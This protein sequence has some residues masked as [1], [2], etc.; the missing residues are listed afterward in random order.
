MQ[1]ISESKSKDKPVLTKVRLDSL[2]SFKQALYRFRG[3]Y[4]QFQRAAGAKL[5]IT[6][7]SIEHVRA[8]I[9]RSEP[10]KAQPLIDEL[11]KLAVELNRLTEADSYHAWLYQH[12]QNL[13][14]SADFLDD[15]PQ[16]AFNTDELPF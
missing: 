3:E 16:P 8:L 1:S 5:A 12:F 7:N 14:H 10:A 6:R 4:L 11:E 15:L 9:S 13:F 2:W